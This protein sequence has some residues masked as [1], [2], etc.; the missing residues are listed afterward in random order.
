MHEPT[1][2][3]AAFGL[4]AEFDSPQPLIDG[5]KAARRTGYRNLDAYSPFPMQE[6]SEA[7]AIGDN[8][9]PLLT[10]AGG[11]FGAAL[12]FGM[13]VYTNLDFPIDVGGRP[14]VAVPAFMLITFELMVLFAVLFSIGGMLA[15]NRLPRL[16]HPLFDVAGFQLASR[17]K[18]FLLIFAN[19]ERFEPQATRE[20]LATL[21]PRRIDLVG[22]TEEPE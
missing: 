2:G 7:L 19:D 1:P 14:L 3:Q 12:G 6:L 10:F 20:F 8:R 17:D 21:G 4:L 18:F 13:Q 9:V 15:I 5:I 22:H 16:N 11:V